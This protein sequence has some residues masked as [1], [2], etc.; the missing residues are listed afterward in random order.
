MNIPELARRREVQILFGFGVVLVGG[1]YLWLKNEKNKIRWAQ[2]TGKNKLLKTTQEPP[3][4]TACKA[5]CAG[6]SNYS[7]C[8]GQCLNQSVQA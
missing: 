7:T 4:V 3:Q 8:M 1:Y 6:S 5:A 2:A